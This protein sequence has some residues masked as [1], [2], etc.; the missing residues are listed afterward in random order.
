MR[1]NRMMMVAGVLMTALAP[2]AQ[3]S[4]PGPEPPPPQRTAAPASPLS[5]SNGSAT[6]GIAGT[7]WF[8]Q[9]A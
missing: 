6:G 1:K 9:G 4:G 5:S 8:G 3:A 7:G 2:A